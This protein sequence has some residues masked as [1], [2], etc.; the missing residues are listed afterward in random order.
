MRATCWCHRWSWAEV[1]AAQPL[2]RQANAPVPYGETSLDFHLPSPCWCPRLCRPPCPAATATSGARRRGALLWAASLLPQAAACAGEASRLPVHA[3][4][5][6]PCW[7]VG[8]GALSMAPRPRHSWG[9][10]AALPALALNQPLLQEPRLR[11]WRV[12]LRG[13]DRRCQSVPASRPRRWQSQ[14]GRVCVPSRFCCFCREDHEPPLMPP[15]PCHPFPAHSLLRLCHPAHVATLVTRS[16]LG[17]P[18]HCFFTGPLSVPGDHAA[19]K[20]ARVGSPWS[21]GTW[22]CYGPGSE[23]R[24]LKCSSVSVVLLLPMLVSPSR[25]HALPAGAPWFL[26]LCFLHR[27]QRDQRSRLALGSVRTSC[28]RAVAPRRPASPS[29]SRPA[30]RTTGPVALAHSLPRTSARHRGPRRGRPGLAVSGGLV[31]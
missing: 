5:S 18:R 28:A 30:L 29:P 22:S 17:R 6:P 9:A 15:R 11:W 3:M 27:R 10:A 24:W 19:L 25:S 1:A 7:A 4:D 26:V 13:P 31:R 21:A 23:G 16:V 2:H 12:A 8:C 20:V 14:A